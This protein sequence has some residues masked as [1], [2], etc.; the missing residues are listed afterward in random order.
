MAFEVL[1]PSELFECQKCGDCC[2]GYGGTFVAEKDIRRIAAF[3]HEAPERFIE[4]YCRRSGTRHVLV[5]A[6]NGYCVFW[7]GLCRIHPVK[8]WMCRIWP[9]IP[10]V[11]IDIENWRVMAASCPGMRTD[12]PDESLEYALRSIL[13]SRD[14]RF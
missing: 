14:R 7:D 4:K 9:F 2:K 3:I 6:E 11:L 13:A 1:A 12:I 5:Q 8:P 10:S